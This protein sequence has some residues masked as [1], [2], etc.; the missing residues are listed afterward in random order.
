MANKVLASDDIAAAGG[1]LAGHTHT[2][3]NITGLQTALDGK[4]PVGSYATAGDIAGKLDASA[5][6][7]ADVFTKVTSLDGALSGLD[8]DLLDGQHGGYFLSWANFSGVPTTFTPSAHVHPISDITG[9]QTALDS[10]LAA[11][12]YTASDILSKLLIV[13]GPGSGLDA[14]LLDGQSSAYYRAWSNLTGVPSTFTPSAHTHSISDVTGLQT[15]LDLR[16]K[17][18]NGLSPDGSG[19]VDVSAGGTETGATIL[20]K[21]ITVDGAGSGLD[22]DLLDGQHGAYYAPVA[23]STFTGET[24]ISESLKLFGDISPATLTANVDNYAPSG[25][26]S[27]TVLKLSSDATRTVTGLAGGSGGLIKSI[28]NSGSNNIVLSSNNSASL[29]S[30]RFDLGSDIILGPSQAVL[31][32]YDSIAS[33]WMP[34]AGSGAGGST[35]SGA[36]YNTF[37][38]TAGQTV[39]SLS[40]SISTDSEVLVFLNGLYMKPTTD[41][42]ISGTTLTLVSPA[43]LNDILIA[44]RLSGPQGADGPFGPKSTSITNPTTSD[45]KVVLFYTSQALT[46]S[47]LVSVLPGGSATPSC[48]ISIKWGSDISGAGTSL[49]TSPSATTSTSTG[50]VVTSFNNPNISAGS[51]VWLDVTAQ[52]GTVPVV[53]VTLEF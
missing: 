7:A 51:F 12:T 37:T 47:K 48:T 38:A 4:Q 23:N 29:A 27:S 16:V 43:V 15:Q 11:S 21:L 22:A 17:T 28:L 40:T 53:H 33:K 45:T 10:K 1:A 36:L 20:A 50:N 42:S 49:I 31:V 2:I 46:V 18:V 34:L 44:I 3:E 30:N 25:F 14:D 24:N 35:S 6:T 13:D 8:A 52:S 32:R 41:Y 39:F 5:Y 26:S 19:N 9:L